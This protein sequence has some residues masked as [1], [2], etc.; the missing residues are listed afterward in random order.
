M[1]WEFPSQLSE[2]IEKEVTEVI[3]TM[4]ENS[5]LQGLVE[6]QLDVNEKQSDSDVQQTGTDYIEA[7]K[8]EMLERNGSVTDYIDLEAQF[9]ALSEISNPSC[10]PVALSKQKIQRKLVVMSSSSEDEDLNNGHPLDMCDDANNGPPLEEI[11]D[12]PSKFRTNNK[13]TSVSFL[14]LGTGLEES[15]V[16]LSKHLGAADGTCFNET[17]KSFDVSCVPES[18]FVPETVNEVETISGALSC[19]NLA[20]PVEVSV[21]NESLPSTF[22]VRKCL[23]KRALDDDLL[24]SNKIPEPSREEIVQDFIDENMETIP[25]Y[26]VMDECSRVDFKAKS[27]FVEPFPS[28]G[29]DVVHKLWR[30]LRECRTDLRHHAATEQPGAFQ[31]VKL[32]CGMSNLISE[33]DLLFGNFQQKDFVSSL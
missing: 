3:T 12:S 19:G 7:K 4:E 33:A 1:P 20:D 13:H 18:T 32:A 29:T 6:E 2:L 11:S 15:E 10:T 28:M 30:E 26:N 21:N 16:D 22:S 17:S 24:V 27:N 31:V 9:H 23:A 25:V 5:S 8:V 14:K